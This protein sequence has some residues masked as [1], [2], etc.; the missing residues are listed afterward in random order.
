MP[1][2]SPSFHRALI[3]LVAVLGLLCASPAPAEEAAAAALANGEPLEV[4]LGAGQEAS[5]QFEVP[6]GVGKLV[7]DL[8]VVAGSLGLTVTGPDGTTETKDPPAGESDTETDD[9]ALTEAGAF[10][11]LAV[12]P[13]AEVA[14]AQVI[15]VELPAAGL[16]EIAVFAAEAEGGQGLL[17]ASYSTVEP[18]N[19]AHEEGELGA[20]QSM[21][22]S[23]EVPEGAN[24]FK[25][26][27]HTSLGSATLATRHG[28]PPDAASY[29][30]QAQSQQ[31][32]AMC[33]HHFPAGG[34]WYVL[35]SAE[36]ESLV[37][38]QTHYTENAGSNPHGAPPGQAKRQE[39]AEQDQDRI[40]QDDEDSGLPPGLEKKNG[41]TPPGRAK[42]NK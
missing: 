29:D 27:L 5:A 18:D 33:I 7:V 9:G 34:T 39:E 35:V 28:S 24:L 2:I 25:A 8:Q 6:E 40:H 22:Y 10:T 4:E 37:T 26:K 12:D 15:T 13:D 11:V 41:K 36:E 32:N 20:G 30:C 21:L 23:V 3:A 14:Y 38:L 17:T 1:A 16:W 42:K 31:G 19:R